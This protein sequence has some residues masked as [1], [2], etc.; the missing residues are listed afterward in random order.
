[1]KIRKYVCRLA[2]SKWKDKNMG[3]RKVKDQFGTDVEFEEEGTEL[4]T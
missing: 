4:F 1:M 2:D 3:N